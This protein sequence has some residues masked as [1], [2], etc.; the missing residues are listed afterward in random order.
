MPSQLERDRRELD[1]DTETHI[2]GSYV[3]TGRGWSAVAAIATEPWDGQKKPRLSRA[4]MLQRIKIM[5]YEYT[6][7]T[8]Q[9]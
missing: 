2:G 8:T 9:P 3:K 4:L 5:W 1:I 6:W 7:N